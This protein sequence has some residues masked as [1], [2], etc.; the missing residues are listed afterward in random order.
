MARILSGDILEFM[1]T[2]YGEPI[3]GFTANAD[4]IRAFRELKESAG[5]APPK[6]ISIEAQGDV[7]VQV[8]YDDQ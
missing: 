5:Y 3:V 6:P 1:G 4:R 8:V 7:I 2:K